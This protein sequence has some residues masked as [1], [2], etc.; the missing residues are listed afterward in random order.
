MR[1]IINADDCGI[2]ESVNKEIEYCIQN[3][4][5]TSTTIMAN[6][7]DFEG[8]RKLY[9][10]YKD[11]ISFGWHINLTQGEPLTE[12]QALLD[13]GYF[14]EEEG[15]VQMKG[16]EFWKKTCFPKIVRKEIKKELMAQFDKIRDNGIRISHAD[17]HQ[18][19]HTS[20]AMLFVIPSLLQ[21]L[22]I[23]KCRRL[24][25]YVES[26]LQR[27]L[28]NLCMAPYKGK[29]IRTTAAFG[30]FR[31]YLASPSLYKGD[32]IIELMVHPG[33]QESVLPTGAAEYETLKKT[34]MSKLSA[35]LVTYWEL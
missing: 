10:T 4:L 26:P 16:M 2:S 28:R 3:G 5:I 14:V 1:I 33:A 22:K 17:S 21:E 13:Y 24:R 29:G 34:D 12:S 15:K 19:I 9:E 7:A 11:S 35:E 18:H 30:P 6:M 8:A 32:G 25:N 20:K 27:V 23:D 31:D